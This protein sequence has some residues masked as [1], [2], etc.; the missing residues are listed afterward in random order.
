M[1]AKTQNDDL[2]GLTP[3]MQYGRV[4]VKTYNLI[5][6]LSVALFVTIGCSSSIPDDPYGRY[7]PKHSKWKFKNAHSDP[8]KL[9]DYNAI[10]CLKDVHYKEYPVWW[11]VRFWSSGQVMLG[12]VDDISSIEKL[13]SFEHTTIGFFKVEGRK[14]F[15][16]TF[17]DIP[18]RRYGY[19]GYEIDKNGDLLDMWTAPGSHRWQR[20]YLDP[21]LRYKRIENKRISIEADW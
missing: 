18:F 6:L 2:G 5:I 19:G 13:N 14:V 15:V 11:T 20:N 21:P 9:I 17:T 3:L 1:Q 12:G 4:G 7:I 16:K 10:Y 8:E